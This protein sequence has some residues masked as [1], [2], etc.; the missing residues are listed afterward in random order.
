MKNKDTL[1]RAKQ[2]LLNPSVSEKDIIMLADLINQYI[3]FT[4]DIKQIG[5]D[6]NLIY[7]KNKMLE[8]IDYNCDKIESGFAK[9]LS[10]R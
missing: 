8:N 4:D 5:Y 1:L 6:D 2:L 7:V 9:R 3:D 10:F